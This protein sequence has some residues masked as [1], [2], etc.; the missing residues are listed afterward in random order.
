M[1]S[2]NL[3]LRMPTLL[4][5]LKIFKFYFMC[6]GVLRVHLH[7]VCLVPVESKDDIESPGIGVTNS[8]SYCVGAGNQNWLLRKSTWGLNC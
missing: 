8:V 4:F 1:L 7:H 6:V 2:G 3:L 5:F